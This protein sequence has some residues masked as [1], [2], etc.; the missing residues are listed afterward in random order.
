LGATVTNIQMSSTGTTLAGGIDV[1]G[2]TVKGGLVEV[3]SGRLVV[4]SL[5]LATPKPAAIADVVAVVAHVANGLAKSG[6]TVGLPLGVGLSGDVRDGQHTTGVNLHDSWVGAP[7]RALLEQQLGRPVT[8][9]NDA[10]A[11]GIAEA[12]YGTARG[13][14]GIVVLLTFG[15]GIGSAI[16][17]DGGL[18][19]N[20]GLGQMPF[21]GRPVEHLL[22][23]V[24]RERR[25]LS[26]RHWASDVSRYVNL[27]DELLHPALVVIGGGVSAQSGAFWSFLETTCPVRPAALGN[28]AGLVG[29]ALAGA[30]FTIIRGSAPSVGGL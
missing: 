2:T 28:E 13:V 20:S 27:I 8:I 24:A 22:S 23:A 1:G 30:E 21:H 5:R 25:R 15:T 17:N 10:D 9:L 4:P 19:P 29:A 12:R 18:L 3:E 7:A 26:W 11:A 14:R 16:L 6:L